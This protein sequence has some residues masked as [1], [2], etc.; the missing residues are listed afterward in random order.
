MTEFNWLE[1]SEKVFEESLKAAPL[2]F[3]KVTKSSLTKGLTKEVGEGGEVRE[4]GVESGLLEVVGTEWPGADA[5]EGRRLMQRH[6]RVRLVPVTAGLVVA[7]DHRDGRIRI[8]GE[9]RVD[10]G[11]A[12]CPGTDDEIVRDRG[13]HGRRP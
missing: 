13:L 11:H 2:P 12:D 7:V 1:N 9:E 4:A 3:R 5:V 6:E 10:E 8:V